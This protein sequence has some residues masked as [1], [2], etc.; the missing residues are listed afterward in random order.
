M[1]TKDAPQPPIEKFQQGRIHAAV[2]ERPAMEGG[3]FRTFTLERRY[4][5]GT[6]DS[7]N[8][9]FKS[10][11]SF[12]KRDADDLVVSAGDCATYRDGSAYGDPCEGQSRSHWRVPNVRSSS[13]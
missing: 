12:S 7:G 4:H 3:S 10:S 13:D 1:T 5:A 2:W 8:K 11:N 6:D 9:T